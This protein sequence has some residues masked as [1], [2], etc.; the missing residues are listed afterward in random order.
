MARGA[1]RRLRDSVVQRALGWE[2]WARRSGVTIGSGCRILS[3]VATSEPWLVSIGDR[4]TVSSRVTL[5]THDGSGWLC[6]DERGRRY[7]Y[8]PVRIGSDVFIG[9]GATIMPGVEIGDRVVVGAGSV[10]TRSVPSETIV[11][12]V[13]ARAVS[14]WDEFMDRVRGWRSAD[15]MQ[16]QTYRERVDSI[17]SPLLPMVPGAMESTRSR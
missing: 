8:A 14:T 13:P 3:N 11:A 7:R 16:G 9:A 15:D 10:V 5:I 2:V 4:V 1:A 6:K 17:V 12:G